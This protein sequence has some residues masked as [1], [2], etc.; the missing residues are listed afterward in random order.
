MSIG[1]LDLVIVIP[2]DALYICGARFYGAR[3]ELTINLHGC[4]AIAIP[5]LP[6]YVETYLWTRYAL[7]C[8]YCSRQVFKLRHL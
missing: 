8:V 4:Y 7:D 5:K 3:D 2:I 1:W 6:M